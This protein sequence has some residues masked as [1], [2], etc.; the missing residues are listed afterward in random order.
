MVE[1]LPTTFIRL[2]HDM[3][4]FSWAKFPRET[5]F[6]FCNEYHDLHITR[7]YK[8]LLHTKKKRINFSNRELEIDYWIPISVT[9]ELGRSDLV[10]WSSKGFI[11]RIRERIRKK[12]TTFSKWKVCRR[13]R[14]KLQVIIKEDP[15]PYILTTK[16]KF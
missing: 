14:N 6:S 4:N 9:I 16:R 2:R 13:E 1:I 12:P 8:M 7:G 5:I 3:F 11:K 15:T 10:V